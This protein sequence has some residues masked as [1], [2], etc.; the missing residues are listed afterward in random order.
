MGIKGLDK[1]I[2]DNTNY[3]IQHKKLSYI[4]GK[5]VIIDMSCLLYRYTLYN[6]EI[7]FNIFKSIFAKFEKYN[8]TPIVVFDGISPDEKQLIVSKRNKKKT[9]SIDELT[10]LKKDKDILK[11]VNKELDITTYIGKKYIENYTIGKYINKVAIERIINEKIIKAEHKSIKLKAKHIIE[12]K[13]YLELKK[14]SF[15]HTHIEADLVCA[16]FVKYGLVDYCISDDT[17]MFPYNCDYVIRNINFK[18]ETINIYNRL[19]ILEELQIDNNQFLDLCIL[20][21]SDYIPRTIGIKPYNI[22]YLIKKYYSIENINDNIKL[23][24]KDKFIKKKIYMNK[25]EK[26]N[27]IRVLFNTT[28]TINDIIDDINIYSTKLN[29]KIMSIC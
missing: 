7:Y 14:I 24:N 26:Y 25:L 27:S 12:I 10:I 13:Q 19:K 16:F 22:L 29:R 5:T 15:I 2:C 20:L 17:D 6:E 9:A 21:G 23:I 3:T 28:F 11:S 18:N 8:I 4:S 1:V